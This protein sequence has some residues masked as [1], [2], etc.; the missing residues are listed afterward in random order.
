MTQTS[1]IPHSPLDSLS[2]LLYKTQPCAHTSCPQ[3]SD[4]WYFHTSTDRR[5]PP[6][7]PGKGR[8]AY[9]AKLCTLG[10]ECED[11]KCEF[12]RNE[13]EL[14]F[15]PLRFKGK[16]CEERLCR[17]KYC[18]FAH[19]TEDLRC[20]NGP[21]KRE[22][23]VPK[24]FPRHQ[25]SIS[26]LT[27]PHL[28]LF[29]QEKG[30]LEQALTQTIGQVSVATSK[31]ACAQC[32]KGPAEGIKSCCGYRQCLACW[33]TETATCT[34]CGAEQRQYVLLRTGSGAGNREKA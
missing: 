13:V 33:H 11:E 14:A 8:F 20:V 3:P 28:M 16:M 15:H 10:P 12:A 34:L 5:R 25:T 21:I 17:R 31:A 27:I 7:V 29:Y 32:H 6:I 4:C 26:A 23:P 30:S 9:E 24:V 2:I 18:P 1:G 19:K 22:I